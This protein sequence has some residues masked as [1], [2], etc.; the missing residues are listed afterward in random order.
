MVHIGGSSEQQELD[1][2]VF[3]QCKEKMRDVKKALK[4]LDQPDPTHSEEDQVKNRQLFVLRPYP[5]ALITYLLC[6]LDYPCMCITKK[7][8]TRGLFNPIPLGLVFYY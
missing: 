7:S 4:A 1:P 5:P 8:S 3:K 2:A 6:R